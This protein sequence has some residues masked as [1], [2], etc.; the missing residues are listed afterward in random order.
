MKPRLL[1][2][3]VSP[4]L[5]AGLA[6]SALILAR[7]A[8]SAGSSSAAAAVS[9][10]LSAPGTAARLAWEPDAQ[11]LERSITPGTV[12]SG[13]RLLIQSVERFLSNEGV[14]LTNVS[15]RMQRLSDPLP[16]L[17]NGWR[18]LALVQVDNDGKGHIARRLLLE[19]NYWLNPAEPHRFSDHHLA[20]ILWHEMHH[21]NYFPVNLRRGPDLAVKYPPRDPAAAATWRNKWITLLEPLE[22]YAAERYSIERYQAVYGPLPEYMLMNSR[23]DMLRHNARYHRLLAELL[24][25][26]K[27]PVAVQ[28]EFAASLPLDAQGNT[29]PN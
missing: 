26:V 14:D 5:L 1:P 2:R 21:I 15:V 10:A 27:D 19:P 7:P 4:S 17:S 13:E 11:A 8:W 22:E 29:L 28:K 9:P 12:G 18:A 23:G 16:G 20:K 3:I 6:L 24:A 25:Q